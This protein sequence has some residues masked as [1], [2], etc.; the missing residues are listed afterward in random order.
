MDV[1][2]NLSDVT[3]IYTGSTLG[4]IPA[5]K[6]PEPKGSSQISSGLTKGF[7]PNLTTKLLHNHVERSWRKARRIKK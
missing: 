3:T 4:E 1:N 7:M 5:L 6:V 2:D